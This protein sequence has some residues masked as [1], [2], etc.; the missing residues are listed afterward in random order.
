MPDAAYMHQGCFLCAI[1]YI[2]PERAGI[3]SIFLE[4]EAH[5][6]K[7]LLRFVTRRSLKQVPFYCGNCSCTCSGKSS[8]ATSSQ[9]VTPRMG[10]VVS[11]K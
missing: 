2:I 9:L 11:F 8:Q 5:G 7:R 10:S 3:A 4:F 1:R 6:R